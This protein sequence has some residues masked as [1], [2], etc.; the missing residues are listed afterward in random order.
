MSIL[1]QLYDPNIWDEFLD[2]VE[3]KQIGNDKQLIKNINK[4]IKGGIEKIDL[5]FPTPIKKEIAKYKNSKKRTIYMFEEPYN[6]YMKAINF[7][8]QKS[9]VYPKQFCINSVAYQ[10]GKSVKR[11][12]ESLKREVKRNKRKEYIKTDFTDYFNSIN[13]KILYEKIDQFFL[14]ED[15]D[16]IDLLKEVLG[17]EEVRIGKEIVNIK[18]KGVMAGMPLSGYLANIYM[19]DI[20]W[21]MYRKQIY[22]TR[23]ADDVIILTNDKEKDK[24]L[25]EDLL[26]PLNVTL[27]PKKVDEGF[28]QDG[29][30]F[31]GFLIKPNEIDINERALKKMKRR[32]KRRSKWFNMWLTKNNV[33]RDIAAKTFIEGMNGKFYAR[34]SEDKTCWME[35]YANTI[36]TDKSLKLIDQYMAQ[37]IRYILS[38]KQKGYKKNAEIPYD[39]LKELGFRPLVNEYWK[40]RK[41]NYNFEEK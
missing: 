19:N 1:K 8:L 12:V 5:N 13:L 17:R 38:G 11:Y 24:K 32:I 2:S 33:K 15:Q 35:W 18:D 29:L 31:L 6:T 30:V 23:Y 21:I 16:L 25:F 41:G 37:Y 9:D 28:T 20:D 39:K 3:N 22:Y 4:I 14:P 26:A 7:I 10:K 36:T 27:N 34:D 40:I